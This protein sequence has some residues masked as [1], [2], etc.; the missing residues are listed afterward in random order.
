MTAAVDRAHSCSPTS[1]RSSRRSARVIM[2]SHS[3]WYSDEGMRDLPRLLAEDLRGGARGEPP[4]G[5]VP[6]TVG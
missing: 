1:S 5:P 3:P 6:D 2:T 4:R